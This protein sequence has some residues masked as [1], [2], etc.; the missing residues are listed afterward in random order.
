MIYRPGQSSQIKSIYKAE[1][2]RTLEPWISGVHEQRVPGM[3]GNFMGPSATS[4]SSTAGIQKD[5]ALPANNLTTVDPMFSE[6]TYTQYYPMSRSTVTPMIASQGQLVQ[7]QQM[8]MTSSSLGPSSTASKASVPLTGLVGGGDSAPL[9]ATPSGTGRKTPL[10]VIS[11]SSKPLK[12]S[13]SSVMA[14]FADPEETFQ[15]HCR[16]FSAHYNVSELKTVIWHHK[17]S[18][19]FIILASKYNQ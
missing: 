4:S 8:T 9:H 6:P 3:V 14:T 19:Y 15:S 10:P 2:A 7:Q 5:Y 11:G 17:T 1:I 13:S 18:L 12:G 16:S